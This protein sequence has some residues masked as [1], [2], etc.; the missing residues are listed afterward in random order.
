MESGALQILKPGM[1]V[2]WEGVNPDGATR[3]IDGDYKVE[4]IDIVGENR[5]LWLT[6]PSG[7]VV[8]YYWD[9]PE[10]QLI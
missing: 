3:G 10:I 5:R 7:K 1:V 2:R 6:V 8:Q 9:Q 4:R